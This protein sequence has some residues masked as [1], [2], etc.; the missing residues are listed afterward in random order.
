MTCMM[1]TK[2]G[3][4][5]VIGVYLDDYTYFEGAGF[6]Q[7]LSISTAPDDKVNITSELSGSNASVLTL[8]TPVTAI[9][10]FGTVQ[11]G[12]VLTATPTPVAATVTYQWTIC[13]TVDGTYVDI[14]GETASTY[15]PVEDDE[16]M[17]LRVVATGYNAY[18]A[19]ATSDATTAVIAAD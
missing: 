14:D 15:E 8:P 11:V 13:D 7:S 5:I 2:N 9:E 18:G 6:V 4:S 12:K 19:E 10:I 1:L 16:D 3:S 17:Y